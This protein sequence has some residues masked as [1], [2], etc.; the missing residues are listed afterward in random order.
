M[1]LKNPNDIIG[2]QTSTKGIS[3]GIKVAGA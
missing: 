2:K 3:W 1:S